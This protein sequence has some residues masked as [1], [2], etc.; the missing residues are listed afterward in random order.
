MFKEYK[1]EPVFILQ[2]K[3][4]SPSSNMID[5]VHTPAIYDP[6]DEGNSPFTDDERKLYLFLYR[7][8]YLKLKGCDISFSY[9]YSKKAVNALLERRIIRKDNNYGLMI[10][11]KGRYFVDR[12]EKLTGHEKEWYIENTT[13]PEIEIISMD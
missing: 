5:L 6:F 7:N 13:S 12:H 11:S 8:P 2:Y 3:T 1:H 9:G 10:N 4:N